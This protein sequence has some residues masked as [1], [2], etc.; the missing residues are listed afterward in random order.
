MYTLTPICGVSK[1]DRCPVNR[2]Q[3]G[4]PYL[5]CLESVVRQAMAM[6]HQTMGERHNLVD[7]VYFCAFVGLLNVIS[8]LLDYPIPFIF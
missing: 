1:A 4:I 2:F 8:I 5:G 6:Q 7:L 3:L